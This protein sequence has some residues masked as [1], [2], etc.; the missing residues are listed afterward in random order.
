MKA[1]GTSADGTQPVASTRHFLVFLGITAAVTLAGFAAQLRPVAGGGLV[2]TRFHEPATLVAQP[3]APM[4]AAVI[5]SAARRRFM[6]CSILSAV[7]PGAQ[8][9]QM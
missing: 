2:E 9:C 1:Q 3:V 8:R 7:W 6:A 4:T 5:A